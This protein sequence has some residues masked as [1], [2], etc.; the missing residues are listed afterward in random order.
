MWQKI[1]KGILRN[2]LVILVLLGVLT[3]FMGYK[4]TQVELQYEFGKL[5]P[6]NDSTNV[7][8]LNFR[9]SYGQDG[10]VIVVSTEI[11]DFYTVEKFAKW[12]EMGQS[13]KNIKIPIGPEGEDNYAFPIDSVFSEALLYNIVKDRDNQKFVLKPICESAPTT[14]TQVDSI[15]D[16][17][18][19]LPFYENMIYKDSSDIHLMMIFVNEGVFNSKNRGSLVADIQKVCNFIAGLLLFAFSCC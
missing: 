19:S 16:V 12:Y 9:N 6:E 7:E 17:V 4:A 5:L 8:Y 15:K 18:H 1:A 3:V 14:Q 2:R 13:I 10:L 11:K